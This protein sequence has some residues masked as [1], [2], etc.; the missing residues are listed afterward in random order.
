MP[1]KKKTIETDNIE[2][3]QEQPKH[4]KNK[5]AKPIKITL[6]RRIL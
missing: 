4:P 3:K 6:P 2:P 5:P 1:R